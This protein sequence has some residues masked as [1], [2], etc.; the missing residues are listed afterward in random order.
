MKASANPPPTLAALPPRPAPRGLSTFFPQIYRTFGLF[1]TVFCWFLGDLRQAN[2]RPIYNLQVQFTTYRSDLQLTGP[3][4]Q[5]KGPDLQLKRPILVHF[6]TN[7]QGMRF[8][9]HPAP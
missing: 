4:L 1:F 8:P 6:G 9:S 5:F 7:F 3:I 2:L